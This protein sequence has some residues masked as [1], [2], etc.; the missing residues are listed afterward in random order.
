MKRRRCPSDRSCQPDDRREGQLDELLDL[1]GAP[2]ILMP[3]R[4]GESSGGPRGPE[5]PGA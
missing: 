1:G 2:A 3:T 5:I 4:L